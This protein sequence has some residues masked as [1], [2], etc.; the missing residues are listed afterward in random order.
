[1]LI[2]LK[3]KF[4]YLGFKANPVAKTGMVAV[5]VA[6]PRILLGPTQTRTQNYVAR[7]L[8]AIA[9]PCAIRNSCE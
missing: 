3:L 9:V 7:G 8:T 5:G 6:V 2:T 1:M 4:S